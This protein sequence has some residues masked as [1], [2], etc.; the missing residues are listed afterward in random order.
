MA[1]CE[2][3][4]GSAGEQ[5]YNI[6]AEIAAIYE[7]NQQANRSG[8]QAVAP[9]SFDATNIADKNQTSPTGQ[10]FLQARDAVQILARQ[11]RQLSRD[12][13]HLSQVMDANNNEYARLIYIKNNELQQRDRD[14]LNHIS[15]TERKLQ[16]QGNELAHERSQRLKLAGKV[17]QAE[18]TL[19]ARD[20]E[21]LQQKRGSARASHIAQQLEQRLQAQKNEFTKQ[22]TEDLRQSAGRIHQLYRIL[23]E[24]Q[25]RLKREQEEKLKYAREA[26]DCHRKLQEYA[27]RPAPL[28]VFGSGS[29]SPSPENLQVPSDQV[30]NQSC[31][32]PIVLKNGNQAQADA[33]AQPGG[34]ALSFITIDLTI[35]DDSNGPPT[36]TI[37]PNTT[38]TL[39]NAYEALQQKPLP[40]YEGEHPL[41]AMK[42]PGAYGTVVGRAAR[43]AN[44]GPAPVA[45]R[46]QSG[47]AV[48]AEIKR[49]AAAERKKRLTKKKIAKAKRQATQQESTDIRNPDKGGTTDDQSAATTPTVTSSPDGQDEY[50]GLED[51]LDAALAQQAIGQTQCAVVPNNVEEDD[52]LE[53]ELEAALAQESATQS[54]YAIVPNDLEERN[55]LAEEFG[56][57]L[58]QAERQFA[59]ELERAA[60]AETEKASTLPNPHKRKMEAYKDAGEEPSAKRPR[61]ILP[62][63]GEL[64]WEG[65]VEWDSGGLDNQGGENSDLEIDLDPPTRGER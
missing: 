42:N 58:D 22:R 27:A 60:A 43:E 32:T 30:A 52:G 51:E 28:E 56:A 18:R 34:K 57:A 17:E 36:S 20:N 7:A 59:Q 31:Q 24:M 33:Q 62:H 16:S 47:K 13:S 19:I 21:L 1:S 61:P 25:N 9:P 50:D 48:S 4:N 11:N 2:L 65:I 64:L 35:A 49:A 45:R 12:N 46:A 41:K 38:S 8:V 23:A 53:G 3:E 37:E 5:Q 54:Q 26:S 44:R 6:N 39:S 40:W 29:S 55:G 14:P 63:G 15:I 10:V